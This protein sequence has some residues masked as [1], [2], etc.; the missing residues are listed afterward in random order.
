[1]NAKSWIGVLV[2]L[3]LGW[4]VVRNLDLAL[5][6]NSLSDM[7]MGLWLLAVVP[8][9]AGLSLRALRWRLALGPLVRNVPFPRM[10][11]YIFIG[12]MFNALLLARAG[13]L[14]RA[15]LVTRRHG[16]GYPASLAV[17]GVERIFDGLFMVLLLAVA[18]W[19]G[20]YESPWLHHLR[21]VA[22]A[23]FGLAAIGVAVLAAFPEASTRLLSRLTAPLPGRI[24]AAL[25]KGIG[26]FITGFSVFR[27]PRRL[28]LVCAA[29]TL[30]WLVEGGFYFFL[31]KAFGF[32]TNWTAPGLAVALLSLA[33]ILPAVPGYV[34]VFEF[35]VAG[36]LLANGVEESAAVAA[37]VVAHVTQV[38]VC[39]LL[40]LLFLW[41]LGIHFPSI[42]GRTLDP[43]TKESLP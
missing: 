14:Y 12:L 25:H 32:S 40:G 29:T 11:P 30:Q 38:G 41:K 5:F 43:P 42:R 23:G 3:L 35:A 1:M 17:A 16:L 37:S 6:W 24:G 26:D 2:T 34:G 8:Y 31:W 18:L 21:S 9:V 28:L 39:T 33:V 27:D 10:I 4:L 19:L 22:L 15:Y 13:D 7:R 20:G 36:S